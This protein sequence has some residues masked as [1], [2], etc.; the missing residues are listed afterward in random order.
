MD[1]IDQLRD[2]SAR[3]F[4]LALLAEDRGQPAVAEELILL[5]FDALKHADEIARRLGP[6]AVLRAMLPDL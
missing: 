3:L 5:S 1:D 6:R 2:R 4:A